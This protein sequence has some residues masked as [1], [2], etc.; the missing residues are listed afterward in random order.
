MSA[1]TVVVMSEVKHSP[2]K[3]AIARHMSR[4]V[5]DALNGNIVLMFCCMRSGEFFTGENKAASEVFFFHG[6]VGGQFLACALEKDFA[7]EQ[8]IC[9]VCDP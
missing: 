4:V 9:P 6:R 7:F 1:G 3:K 2:M 5:L 8:Q